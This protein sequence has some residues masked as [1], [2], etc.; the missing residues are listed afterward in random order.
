MTTSTSPGTGTPAVPTTLVSPNYWI[1][2]VASPNYRK[3]L[4]SLS[5]LAPG[6][7]IISS[8]LTASQFYLTSS[9]GQLTLYRG[10]GIPPLYLNVENPSDKTQR[11]LYTEFRESKNEYGTFGF[12]GDTLTWSVAEIKR[13]N[14][15]AWLVCGD[16][17][18]LFVNTGAYGWDTPAGCSDQTVSVFLFL[19]RTH[20]IYI[21]IHLL[22]ILPIFPWLGG[23]RE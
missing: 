22:F 18:E 20:D 19:S 21:P 15:A 8:H 3:Y 9:D 11:K 6:K 12:Q 2:A 16:D 14:E 17:K 7:A 10:A 13:P 5:P 23:I 1:R 4:Q